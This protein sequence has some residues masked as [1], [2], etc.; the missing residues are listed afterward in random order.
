MPWTIGKFNSKISQCKAWYKSIWFL[1]LWYVW[2]RT[3]LSCLLYLLSFSRAVSNF[4]SKIRLGYVWSGRLS[5]MTQNKLSHGRWF[6]E[7]VPWIPQNMS[8]SHWI[9]TTAVRNHKKSKQ[10]LLSYVCLCFWN[11]WHGVEASMRK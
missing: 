2:S 10:L 6:I 8:Y 3:Y 5:H 1:K 9:C 4:N 7:F 11:D